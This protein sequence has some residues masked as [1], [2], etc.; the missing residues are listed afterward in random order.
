MSLAAIAIKK[1]SKCIHGVTAGYNVDR[2]ELVYLL[3]KINQLIHDLAEGVRFEL[4]APLP[5][6]RFSRPV[7]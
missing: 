6:R 7:H 1:S 3:C 2:I 4:T 5:A